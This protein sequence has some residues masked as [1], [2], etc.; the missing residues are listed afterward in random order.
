LAPGLAKTR[1][2][3]AGED[4]E[5]PAVIDFQREGTGEDDEGQGQPGRLPREGPDGSDMRELERERGRGR[6]R[7]REC[8]RRR[9]RGQPARFIPFLELGLDGF[10]KTVR[11]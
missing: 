4:D 8:R 11:N 6:G 10:R 9:G 7:E 1:R 2:G 5:G 3:V